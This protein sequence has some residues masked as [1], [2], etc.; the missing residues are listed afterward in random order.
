MARRLILTLPAMVFV[1][2][3]GAA[4]WTNFVRPL[5]VD[6][7]SFWAAAR[8]A[9]QDQA[10]AVYDVAAHHSVEAT[11]S[12]IGGFLLPFPYPPPFLLFLAPFGLLPYPLAFAVW[13]AATGLL[14]VFAAGLPKRLTLGFPVVVSSGLVGQ[15]GFLTTGVF[16]AGTQCLRARPF[17][18]GAILGLMVIKPQLALLLPVALLAGGHWRAIVGAALS[19]VALVALALLLFGPETYRGFFQMLPRYAS[20][21]GDS[22]WPWNELMSPFAFARWFGAGQTAAWLIHGGIAAVAGVVVW[23]AWRLDWEAKVPVLAAASLLI[24]PYLFT[25]DGLLLVVP[26]AW[27]AT[28]NQAYA[29]IIWGLSLVPVVGVLSGLDTGPN[30]LPLAAILALVALRPRSGGTRPRVPAFTILQGRHG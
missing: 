21:M 20:Y 10:A 9:L 25:Y 8:M 27:L 28:R 16:L 23:R 30:T 29:A 22:L 17:L 4:C 19:S 26:F 24:P 14:Y 5:A 6:F 12:P 11:A 7:V 3:V 2:V 1:I 18:G 15:T 13:V